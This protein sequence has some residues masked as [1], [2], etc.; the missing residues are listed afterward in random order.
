ML[1]EIF[2]DG[3]LGFADVDGEKEQAFGSKLMADLIDESSFFGAEAAPGGPELEENDF[4]FDGLVSEFFAG[5]R[6]GAE[7]RGRLFVFRG[8]EHTDNC[9]EQNAEEC[10]AEEDGSRSHGGNV[11]QDLM[12]EVRN[13]NCEGGNMGEESGVQ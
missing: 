13:W 5:S 8:S 6:G 4:T 3:F 1:L 7:T 2:F 11:A 12:L 10:A 9:D